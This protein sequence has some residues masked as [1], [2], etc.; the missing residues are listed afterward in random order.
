MTYVTTDMTYVTTG[1]L[2]FAGWYRSAL[3]GRKN[4]Y[5]IAGVPLCGRAITNRVE[6][7]RVNYHFCLDCRG[8]LP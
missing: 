3:K 1:K 5:L 6:R 7:V 4:H 8:R 2:L